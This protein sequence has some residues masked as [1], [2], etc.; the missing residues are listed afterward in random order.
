M[1][2]KKLFFAT[3]LALSL[4]LNVRAIFT[5]TLT[6]DQLGSHLIRLLNR[7]FSQ[8]IFTTDEQMAFM[9]LFYKAAI[10]YI[11]NGAFDTPANRKI[12]VRDMVRLLWQQQTGQ[13]P[14]QGT[15]AISTSPHHAFI[16]HFLQG[17]NIQASTTTIF[18]VEDEN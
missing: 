4:T 11:N 5:S 12:A 18:G 3:V 6:T 14:T 1:T 13:D 10:D 2:C 8:G 16:R 9:R 15:V 7:G 17:V